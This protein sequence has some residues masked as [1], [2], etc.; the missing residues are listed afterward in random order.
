MNVTDYMKIKSLTIFE[1]DVIENGNVVTKIRYDAE[2]MSSKQSLT[3]YRYSVR[4]NLVT[5]TISG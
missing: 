2:S 4:F 3:N 1:A 5:S